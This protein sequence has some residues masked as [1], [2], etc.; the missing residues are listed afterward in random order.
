[1]IDKDLIK[2]NYS[3]MSDIQ[4]INLAKNEGLQLSDVSL[5]LLQIEFNKRNLSL[6]FFENIKNIKHIQQ[7]QEIESDNIKENKKKENSIWAYAFD[8]KYLGKNNEEL[9]KL[10]LSK[11]LDDTNSKLIIEKLEEV[12]IKLKNNFDSE[13]LTGG[14]VFCIGVFVTL[15]TLNKGINGGS[16]IIAWGAILFGALRFYNGAKNKSRF[17]RILQNIE[18]EKS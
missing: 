14:L 1:M 3:R 4:L 13:M 5:E 11:G 10:L 12:S 15:A 8:Q 6:E 17:S 18:N 7:L 9:H 16:Y 2:E